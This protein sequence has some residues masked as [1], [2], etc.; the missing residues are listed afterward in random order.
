MCSVLKR[1]EFIQ[2]SELMATSRRSLDLRSFALLSYLQVICIF[3]SDSAEPSIFLVSIFVNFRGSIINFA[4]ESHSGWRVNRKQ[5]VR[6]KSTAHAS[7]KRSRRLYMSRS[8]IGCLYFV[9]LA[10]IGYVVIVSCVR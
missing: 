4:L 5:E 6:S 10:L 7:E 1:S 2:R 3:A 9:Y 8:L